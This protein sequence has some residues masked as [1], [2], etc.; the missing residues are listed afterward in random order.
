MS[1]VCVYEVQDRYCLL[2]PAA[3]YL[4]RSERSQYDATMQGTVVLVASSVFNT[5][6]VLAGV[7]AA[8]DMWYDCRSR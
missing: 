4:V 8:V 2:V 5:I 3:S 6:F 7:S 1:P